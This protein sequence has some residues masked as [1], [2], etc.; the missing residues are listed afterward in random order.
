MDGWRLNIVYM[1]TVEKHLAAAP[2]QYLTSSP[3]ASFQYSS[4][5][6]VVCTRQKDEVR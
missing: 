3:V 1:P 5:M 2:L 6:H 4:I